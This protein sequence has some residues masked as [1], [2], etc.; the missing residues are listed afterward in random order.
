VSNQDDTSPGVRIGN[1]TGGIHNSLFAGRDISDATITVGDK[2]MR[3]DETP[4]QA[5]LAQLMADISKELAAVMANREELGA[6]SAAA[7]YAVQG[8]TECVNSASKQLAGEISPAEATSVH[9]NLTDAATL[10]GTVVDTVDRDA[11]KDENLGGKIK[12]VATK[13]GPLLEKLAVAA[14]WVSKLWLGIPGS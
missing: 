6:V 5:D 9:R 13:L 8:A 7:P 1:V 11:D 4:T 12:S 14:V 2:T 3:A 10:M